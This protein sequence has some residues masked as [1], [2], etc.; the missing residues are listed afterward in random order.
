MQLK[1]KQARRGSNQTLEKL[2]ESS[3]C[4]ESPKTPE[5]SK[6]KVRKIVSIYMKPS[7]IC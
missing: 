3:I 2:E 6:E 1:L 4:K 5:L 7:L